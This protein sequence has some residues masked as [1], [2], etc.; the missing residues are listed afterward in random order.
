MTYRTGTVTTSSN[1]GANLIAQIESDLL[2]NGWVKVG[3]N[4]VSGINTWNVYRS[5]GTLNSIGSDFH[6]GLC[7]RTATPGT[8]G[9]CIFRAWDAVNNLATGFPPWRA[10][11]NGLGGGPG[12][13]YA[14]ALTSA[15]ELNA[16]AQALPSQTND[17][18]PNLGPC[19]VWADNNYLGTGTNGTTPPQWVGVTTTI[20]GADG[21]ASNTVVSYFAGIRSVTITSGGSGYTNGATVTFTGG[22][23]TVQA[24]GTVQV[25]ASGVVT[26]IT[27]TNS[28]QNYGYTS[29]PTI[30]ITGVGGVGSG[31]TAEV[32]GTSSGGVILNW[33]CVP[34]VTTAGYMP[35]SAISY[36][37]Q[38]N[39]TSGSLYQ[40]NL[41][42]AVQFNNPGWNYLPALTL[43]SSTT[44]YAYSVTVDRLILTL[45]NNGSVYNQ[46]YYLGAY[47]S[48]L[49]S[50]ADALPVCWAW[51][52]GNNASSSRLVPSQFRG[53][54]ITEPLLTALE[55]ALTS[56]M[57]SNFVANTPFGLVQNLS[58]IAN[59]SP[60]ISP[61]VDEGYSGRRIP[62][63]GVLLGRG[64]VG[65]VNNSTLFIRGFLKDVYF[66]GGNATNW[67]DEIQWTLGGTNYAAVRASDG[68][69]AYFLKV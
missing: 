31:A 14:W 27:I 11:L 12:G 54:A 28:G 5:P 50:S 46:A 15:Y 51:L 2:A 44:D 61:P 49:S 48:W 32:R 37:L 20:N 24:T 1:G 30:T 58:G 3:T 4:V 16:P 57:S 42:F 40:F 8:F 52:G 59:Y 67:L 60:V 7:Y 19:V 17:A 69:G 10:D 26:G 66:C 68:A 21:G 45:R 64:S 63:R 29:Q 25:N 47:D 53:A 18:V 39:T 9:F 65:T 62:T 38:P 36:S 34:V 56:G 33:R 6:I 43:G 23:A 35:T 55:A 13:N 41:G 22:G